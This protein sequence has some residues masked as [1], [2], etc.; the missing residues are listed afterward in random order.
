MGSLA[1][2]IIGM[3]GLA[4]SAVI[5]LML[6]PTGPPIGGGPGAGTRA[7]QGIVSE[8]STPCCDDVVLKLRGDQ[9][10]YYVQGALA[11]GPDFSAWGRALIDQTVTLDVARVAWSEDRPT[12]Q[13]VPV[14]RIAVGESVFYPVR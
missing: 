10:T 13:M 7:V 2:G 14:S 4:L 9:R 3:I 8:V 1:R 12:Q 11:S 5:V 6:V